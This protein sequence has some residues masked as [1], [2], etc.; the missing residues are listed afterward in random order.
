MAETTTTTATCPQCRIPFF[1]GNSNMSSFALNT[2]IICTTPVKPDLQ[3]IPEELHKFMLPSVRR[4]YCNFAPEDPEI[5]QLKAQI[6]RFKTRNAQLTKEIKTHTSNLEILEDIHIGHVEDAEAA[7]KD[8]EAETL[9]L[10]RVEEYLAALQKKYRRGVD[11]YRTL[12]C[13]QCVYCFGTACASLLTTGLSSALAQKLYGVQVSPES[14]EDTGSTGKDRIMLPLPQR[15][16]V[17]SQLVKEL[18]RE[19]NDDS[20]AANN[21]AF[22]GSEVVQVHRRHSY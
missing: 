16:D 18:L 7:V 17:R 5:T 6:G 14:S 10:T 19:G 13:Q 12:E 9:K 11:M 4:V 8:E 20:V 2:L 22:T 15:V 1:I 21:N 3:Y